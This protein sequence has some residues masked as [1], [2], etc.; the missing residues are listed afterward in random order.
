M[1][2]VTRPMRDSV[3]EA[4]GGFRRA[5]MEGYQREGERNQEL[6]ERLGKH[7]KKEE[8]RFDKVT[9][10][11]LTKEQWDEFKDWRKRRRE[12]EQEL[13]QQRGP[14]GGMGGPGGRRRRGGP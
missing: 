3:Q 9:R 6:V 5:R 10:K 4:M 2:A 13:R 11:I 12:T 7:L 14:E 8:G 1:M